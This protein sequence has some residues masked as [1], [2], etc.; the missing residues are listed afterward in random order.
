MA[1]A[2]VMIAQLL[3]RC[4]FARTPDLA[5]A[6]SGG[7]D[8]LAMLALACQTNVAVTAFHVDHQLR[9]GSSEEANVVASAAERLGAGFEALTVAV[10]PG[11]NLEERARIARFDVL[12]RGAATGHTADDQAETVVLALLRGSAWAGL[13]GMDPGPTKPILGLRRAETVGLCAHLGLTPVEDP[14]NNDPAFRRNRVRHELMPLLNDIAERDVVPVLARQA[15]LLRQGGHVLGQLAEQLD[16]TDAKALAGAHPAVAREAVRNWLWTQTG[17]AHPPDL[18]A[19]DRVLGV[20]RLE[21]TA[22]EVSGAFRVERS[23]Q[24]LR[25]V[26][27]TR[28]APAS[29]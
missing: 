15:G 6:V 21:A 29:N 3:E 24:Q 20:A 13:S 27:I 7:P 2:S 12:P 5:L 4:T 1:D 10:A 17:A 16:P 8:S 28:A 25:I 18:A 22:T 14:S 9:P 26:P 23:Q 19:V 11:P